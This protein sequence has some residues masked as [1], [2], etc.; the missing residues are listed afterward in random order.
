MAVM[1]G[2]LSTLFLSGRG[3][4]GY[5]FEIEKTISGFPI[6]VEDDKLLDL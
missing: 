5:I 1:A 2:I 3:K 6:N 4:G